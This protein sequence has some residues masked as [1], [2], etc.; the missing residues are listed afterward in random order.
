MGPELN[1]VRAE[2]AT[3]PQP[4]EMALIQRPLSKI[5]PT[6]LPPGILHVSSSLQPD[7]AAFLP[8]NTPLPS[9]V[10]CHT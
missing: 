2:A 4:Q 3:W 1:K 6:A 5:G 7:S 8:T 10:T 9:F